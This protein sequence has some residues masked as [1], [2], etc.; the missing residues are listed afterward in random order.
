MTWWNTAAGAGL[1]VVAF[2]F[3]LIIMLKLRRPAR[4]AVEVKPAK[5]PE[6]PLKMMER[7]QASEEALRSFEE[8]H[9]QA[10]ETHAKALRRRYLQRK[11]VIDGEMKTVADLDPTK[12]RQIGAYRPP[13]PEQQYMNYCS[14]CNDSYYG[15]RH[16]QD[17]HW[18]MGHFDVLQYASIDWSKPQAPI[19]VRSHN[20]PWQD[21]HE[22]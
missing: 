2:I 6:K 19:D 15:Q 3:A 10:Q 13:E 20:D 5:E 21:V 12:H 22:D 16:T 4:Y 14:T 7:P 9:R 11:V 8:E 17:P 18:L 1:S